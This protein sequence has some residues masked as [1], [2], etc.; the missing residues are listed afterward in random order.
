MKKT[1]LGF[2]GVIVLASSLYG[3]TFQ[4]KD[5]I[6][7]VESIVAVEDM[8]PFKN[9]CVDYII[10]ERSS[11]SQPKLYTANGVNYNYNGPTLT[12]LES[13]TNLI[14][15]ATGSC[16][17]V[18]TG[19]ITH[20][21]LKYGVLTSPT[22]GKIWLDRNLGAT[23]ACTQ[24]NQTTNTACRGDYYQFGRD[25]DGHEKGES[26]RTQVKKTGISSQDSSFVYNSSDWTTADSNA[27]QRVLKWS[28]TDGTSVCPV[29]FRVPTESEFLAERT[30]DQF[31]LLNLSKNLFLN[32]PIAGYRD[33]WTG[34]LKD[35]YTYS[36]I[37]TAT[38]KRY[39]TIYN[40]TNSPLMSNGS[41]SHG[42]NIRCI[43]N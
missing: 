14:V 32:F 8:S 27:S 11:T 34:Y 28:K 23:E 31:G 36:H 13:G 18:V 3:Y 9:T 15:K 24:P 40:D 17:V 33:E 20:K 12:A 37:W 5:G 35:T 1:V 10:A 25:T 22:T 43:R 29:G 16:D 41:L 6:Q 26:P 2:V 21:G 39:L 19:L 7:L 38:A 42:A 30:L 4:I